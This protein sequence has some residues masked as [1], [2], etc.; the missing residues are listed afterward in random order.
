MPVVVKRMKGS[1]PWKIIE[2]ST[3]KIVGES[4]NEKDASASARIINESLR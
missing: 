4:S 3:G 1:K 2:V